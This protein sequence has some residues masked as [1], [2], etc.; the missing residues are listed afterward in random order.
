MDALPLI[1]TAL[2]AVAALLSALSALASWRSTRALEAD[3]AHTKATTDY[4]VFRS[5][6][7]TY[8]ALYPSLWQTLGPWPDPVEV[9]P[10]L[11]RSVH[12]AAQALSSVYNAERLGVILGG[13]AAYLGELFLDWLRLPKA[14]EV[15]DQVFSLQED[16]WPEGFVS[17]I[18]TGLDRRPVPPLE[19]E[20]PSA[21]PP[22]REA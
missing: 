9:D 15:W 18:N 11:R 4:E 14:R 21:E 2:A 8:R 13:Q 12:D 20:S 19:N 16:T 10:D 7:D 6:E 1:S 17:W 5:F 3:F 22:Q